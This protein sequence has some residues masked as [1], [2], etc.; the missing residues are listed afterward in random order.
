G[1]TAKGIG[2]YWRI[3]KKIRELKSASA[4]VLGATGALYAVRRNLLAELPSETILDDVFI[5]LHV[6]RQGARVVFED[7]ARAWDVADLWSGRE[8]ARKVRTLTGN[9]QLLQLAPWVLTSDNPVRFQ[10]VWS[11]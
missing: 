3:E 4:S 5:P 9:D 7:R 8:F 6:A 1:E 2:L 10:F 11:K